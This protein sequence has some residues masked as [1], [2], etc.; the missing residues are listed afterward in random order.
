MA[1]IL[2]IKSYNELIIYKGQAIYAILSLEDVKEFVNSYR[3]IKIRVSQMKENT[4]DIKLSKEIKNVFSLDK[5]RSQL[6]ISGY[7][8][9]KEFIN[10][11]EEIEAKFRQ[12]KEV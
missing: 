12:I 9:F 5:G 8:K 11:D 7:K 4:K 6:L 3:L 2:V 1:E 10:N